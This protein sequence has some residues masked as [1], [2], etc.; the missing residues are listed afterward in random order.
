MEDSSVDF[1]RKVFNLLS[2]GRVLETNDKNDDAKSIVDFKHPHELKVGFSLLFC[3][4]CQIC[5]ALS[6]TR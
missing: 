5:C 6:Y 3:C 4:C 1:L 2:D